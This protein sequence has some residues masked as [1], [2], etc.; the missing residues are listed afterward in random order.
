MAVGSASVKLMSQFLFGR[1]SPFPPN[2]EHCPL[3]CASYPLLNVSYRGIVIGT[4]CWGGLVLFFYI[5]SFFAIG[6]TASIV[7]IIFN[8]LWG[9][10]ACVGYAVGI[11][12]GAPPPLLDIQSISLLLTS[13]LRI[14]DLTL[15]SSI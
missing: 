4:I 9:L 8:M 10:T 3:Y 13:S 11:P 15:Y 14:S 2:F 12:L 6:A 5:L 1:I 7:L